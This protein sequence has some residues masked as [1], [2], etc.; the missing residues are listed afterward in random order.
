MTQSKRFPDQGELYGMM[1]FAG[2]GLAA[3]SAYVFASQVDG[4]PW[5]VAACFIL[6]GIYILFGC[7]SSY[8]VEERPMSVSIAYTLMMIIFR[9][10]RCLC[11]PGER[12]GGHHAPADGESGG[13]HVFAK[14]R[15]SDRTRT[16]G[17][18]LS[19]LMAGRRFGEP[20]SPALLFSCLSF[21]NS[22][23]ICD[24]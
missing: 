19:C 11:E 12:I 22:V 8:I 23:L 17:G 4:E 15:V 24:S 9:S 3:M 6:S 1:A 18:Y 7:F 5:Q 16:L 21:Y 13:I 20:G 2:T 14:S 10:V